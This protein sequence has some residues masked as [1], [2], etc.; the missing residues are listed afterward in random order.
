LKE[1]SAVDLQIFR[2]KYQVAAAAPTVVK[3]SHNVSPL[4]YQQ[5][6][7]KNVNAKTDRK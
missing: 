3:L 7:S 5:R 6:I 1:Q 2:E 4:H